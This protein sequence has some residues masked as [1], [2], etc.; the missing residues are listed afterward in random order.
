MASIIE[1]ET[2]ARFWAQTGYKP[3][4]RLSRKDPRD[5]EMMRVWRGIRDQV[6]LEFK[7]GTLVTTFDHPVTSTALSEA[8]A[9][10]QAATVHLEAAATTP[11]PAEAAAHVEAAAAHAEA[12]ATRAQ[13]AADVQPPST[14]PRLVEEAA[15]HAAASPPAPEAQA[16]EHL[17][18]AQILAAHRPPPLSIVDRETAARFWAQT[19][20][21]PGQLLD[22]TDGADQRMH[23]LWRAIHQAV[24]RELEQGRLVITYNDPV[25]A[26]R[27][28]EARAADRA[29]V[30]SLEAAAA[31]PRRVVDVATA[32]SAAQAAADRTRE[33]AARQPP[34]VPPDLAREVAREFTQTPS[35]ADGA[36]GHMAREQARRAGNHAAEIHR[37]HARRRH[38]V[39][40][41]VS[42]DSLRAYR[43]VAG[44]LAVR[45]ADP[46]HW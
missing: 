8:A 19:G 31:N 6:Q 39:R 2:D 16:G 4:V 17:A 33:A 38:P 40:S 28:A 23:R 46:R 18:H 26:R 36:R 34:T 10:H 1:K 7:G 37:H 32:A 43:A 14:S 9:A 13:E 42:P 12:A 21:R 25:V 15:A 30:A 20:Y 45:E 24:Q 35:H 5:V 22:P 3:G 27:I 44:R 41:A 29:A 11:D